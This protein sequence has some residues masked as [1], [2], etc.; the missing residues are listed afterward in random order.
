MWRARLRYRLQH[1]ARAIFSRAPRVRLIHHLFY[2]YNATV[3]GEDNGDMA[4]NGERRVLERFAPDCRVVF[5]VGANRGDW[6]ELALAANPALT[7]HCF[8]PLPDVF[9][10][11]AEHSAR[12]EWRHVSCHPVA[13]SDTDGEATIH[14]GS[15]SMHRRG[16][17]AQ[18]V[19]CVTLDAFCAREGI[20]SIDLL[21]IDVEGNELRVLR[22]ARRM[23]AE[24][25]VARIQFEYGPE[26]AHARVLLK[27]LF[28]L[29]H[30]YGFVIHRILPRR[31]EPVPAY[32]TWLENFR[33]K[34]FL[35]L[36][37]EAKRAD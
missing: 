26:N 12:P 1:S 25:R 11:L 14:S 36:G 19:G 34:N 29:L 37:P 16:G 21:K 13:V 18:S 22:G 31:I 15:Q 2:L 5:D 10:A 35:A 33:Y 32:T 20:E 28:E 7:V 6:T 24:G 4:I 27:D 17:R 9:E 8:E 3:D 30:S 23:L